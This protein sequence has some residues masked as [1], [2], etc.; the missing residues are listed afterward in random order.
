M[1]SVSRW[2]EEH[3]KNVAVVHCK[4]GKG[5]TGLMICAY[6]LHRYLTN[7]TLHREGDVKTFNCVY[8]FQSGEIDSAGGVGVLRFHPDVRLQGC[9]DPLAAAVRGILYCTYCTVLYCSV[10]TWTTTPR[11]SPTRCSTTPSR[12]TS[13][14]SSSTPS[15]S[16]AGGSRRGSSR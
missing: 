16:W 6:L 11:W 9:D 12:C 15:P 13:P 7:R 4:A 10:G 1:F 5:R 8:L 3:E 14:A 2:L